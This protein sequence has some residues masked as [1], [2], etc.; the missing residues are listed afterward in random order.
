MAMIVILASTPLLASAEAWIAL[1]L[2][3]AVTAALAFL[4]RP[5]P[6]SPKVERPFN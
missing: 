1:A 4:E 5:S 3:T 2:I 6:L